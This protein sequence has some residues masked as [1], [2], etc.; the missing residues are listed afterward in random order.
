M[1]EAEAEAA[2]VPSVGISGAAELQE[3]IHPH[4]LSG[5]GGG[6]VSPKDGVSAAPGSFRRR[7][8]FP[9]FVCRWEAALNYQTLPKQVG[10][11]FKH[12]L[13]CEGDGICSTPN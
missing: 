1:G 9:V 10:I 11:V 12:W 3:T 8:L 6:G 4:S 13:D 2:V 7:A 5:G